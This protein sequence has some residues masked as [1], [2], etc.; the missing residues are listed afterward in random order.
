MIGMP[1]MTYSEGLRAGLFLRTLLSENRVVL[2][3]HRNQGSTPVIAS[4]FLQRM[5]GLATMHGIS[6]EHLVHSVPFHYPFPAAASALDATSLRLNVLPR[7]W[8]DSSR[9]RNTLSASDL[10]QYLQCPYRYYCSRILNLEPEEE[11]EEVLTSQDFGTQVHRI[12]RAFWDPDRKEIE[13]LPGPFAGDL[14]SQDSRAEEMLRS[15]AEAEFASVSPDDLEGQRSVR[16]FLRMIPDIVVAE[17]QRWEEGWRPKVFEHEFLYSPVADTV[18]FRCRVDRVDLHTDGEHLAVLDYKTGYSPGDKE[19][20]QGA[21]PQLFLYALAAATELNRKPLQLAYYNLK[22]SK[23]SPLGTGNLYAKNALSAS[24]ERRLDLLPQYQALIRQV[25]QALGSGN[26]ADFPATVG[27]T[28][29]FCSYTG[30]CRKPE[31]HREAE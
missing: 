17:Q 1:A 16:R 19:L 9:I 10:E 22:P 30:V 12:M 4:R 2:S 31:V 15:I 27:V 25:A 29:R 20:A 11:V 23:T 14:S 18:T 8:V 3:C 7:P 28:C 21:R 24:V 5:L 13:H 6:R 26:A